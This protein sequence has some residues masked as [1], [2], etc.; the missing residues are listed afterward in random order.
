MQALQASDML[1]QLK[2]AFGLP[3]ILVMIFNLIWCVLNS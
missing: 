2:L 1:A 3:C